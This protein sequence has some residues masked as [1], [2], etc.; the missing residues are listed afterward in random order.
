MRAST[1]VLVVL[2][3]AL[4]LLGGNALPASAHPCPLTQGY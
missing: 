1:R 4:S 2:L 3:L